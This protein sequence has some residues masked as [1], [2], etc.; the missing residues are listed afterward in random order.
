LE[1]PPEGFFFLPNMAR[2]LRVSRKKGK[3]P[4]GKG[5]ETNLRTLTLT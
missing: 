3:G 5:P 1:A 4:K 2:F